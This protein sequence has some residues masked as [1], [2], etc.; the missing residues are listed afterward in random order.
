MKQTKTIRGTIE[1]FT[2]YK[3]GT[4]AAGKKW[5]LY[6][7]LINGEKFQ[8]FDTA[9]AENNGAT[10]E[11]IFEEEDKTFVNKEGQTIEYTSRTLFPFKTAKKPETIVAEGEM[12]VIEDNEEP[13]D[14]IEE[15]LKQS[16]DPWIKKI[17]NNQMTIL[18]ELEEI[19]KKLGIEK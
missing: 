14:E 7:G 13:K 18:T 12:P 11:F 9:Y 6:K 4:S 10:G 16:D 19:N 8:T 15:G 17:Y 1:D 2:L 5:A 3:T